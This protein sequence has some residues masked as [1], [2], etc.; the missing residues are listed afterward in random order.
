M[1]VTIAADAVREQH[2][3]AAA[4]A[5]VSSD[6]QQWLNTDEGKFLA[7]YNSDMTG[8]PKGAAIL[9]PPLGA[10]PNWP[11]VIRQLRSTLP[12][13][14]WS[15]LSIQMPVLSSQ[16]TIADYADTQTSAVNRINAAIAFMHSK[17]YRNIAIIGKGLGAAAGASYLAANPGQ[18]VQA[19]IGISMS[20]HQNAAD[21][22][23]SPNSIR[24]LALPILDIYGS[25]DQ[26][27]VLNSADARADAARQ[28][29]LNASKRFKSNA[30]QRSATAE[31]AQTRRSGYIAFR[32]IKITGADTHFSGAEQQVSKRIIGWLKNHAGG[33]AAY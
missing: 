14:G 28:A 18:E 9:L 4:V 20:G 29:S 13:S 1:T 5:N 8:S 21:W 25:N 11:G 17:G 15:T 6:I 30:F 7:L 32:R 3:A 19:F 23:Y 12:H 27:H 24:Q 10:H 31:S 26:H 33:I 22:L 16:S 2:L